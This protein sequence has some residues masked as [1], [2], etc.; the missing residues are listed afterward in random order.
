MNS[1]GRTRR[2]NS[3]HRFSTHCTSHVGRLWLHF[4]NHFSKPGSENNKTRAPFETLLSFKRPA[5]FPVYEICGNGWGRDWKQ[6]KEWIPGKLQCLVEEP[7][8]ETEGAIHDVEKKKKT[9]VYG[10]S[11]AKREMLTWR[12]MLTV[13]ILQR[14]WLWYSQEKDY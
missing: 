11:K 14:S 3:L 9:G 6:R 1:T 13:S 12:K 5:R 4:K 8:K 10:E 2:E 7:A